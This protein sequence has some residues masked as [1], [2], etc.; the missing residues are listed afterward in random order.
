MMRLL[1]LGTAFP[2]ARL[3]LLT[4]ALCALWAAQRAPLAPKESRLYRK[5][6]AAQAFLWE[7]SMQDGLS[8]DIEADPDRSG[9]IGI[10]WSP[11]TTTLGS[12]EAKRCATDPL[13]AVRVLR[14]FD[15][16]DLREGDRIAVLA[17]SSFPGLLYAVLAAAEER[18]LHVSLAVSLGSSTW[19]ANRPEAPWPVLAGML[20]R[21]GFLE[22][23]PAFYTLGGENENGSGMPEEART[24]LARAAREDGTELFGNTTLEQVVDRKMHLV[25]RDSV[26]PAKLVVSI[27]GSEGNLGRDPAVLRL[28]P[29][30]IFPEEGPRAGD[31]AI[32]MALRAGYP[33]LHLLNLRGLADREGIAW[34]GRHP[35]FASRGSVAASFLGLAL[36]AVV[37]AT[38]RRWIWE[39]FEGEPGVEL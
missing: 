19:G 35:E 8:M 37:L 1:R 14:W 15:A 16:L 33:V 30:M 28:A 13:W 24:L 11:T 9:F 23:R 10:E 38:H 2:A 34:N 39:A 20:R 31:G 36:F 7:A 4:V 29:G 22:T 3:I 5:V 21:G 12:L 26:G 17:S 25:L 18:G 27:G 6:A 32:G